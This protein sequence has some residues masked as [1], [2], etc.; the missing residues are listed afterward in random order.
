MHESKILMLVEIFIWFSNYYHY[1]DQPI[2]RCTISPSSLTHFHHHNITIMSEYCHFTRLYMTRRTAWERKNGGV[3]YANAHTTGAFS[4]FL[5]GD[6]PQP[7]LN[8]SGFC[9][10][11]SVEHLCRHCHQ[12][13]Q[14]TAVCSEVHRSSTSGDEPEEGWVAQA[15]RLSTPDLGLICLQ[16]DLLSERSRQLWHLWYL[17][18][19]N[20]E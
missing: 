6:P 14:R 16:Y 11:K 13:V 15:Q 5:P 3:A 9:M 20:C 19:F 17:Y 10:W 12:I 1:I 18:W 8:G 2:I 7:S 4:Q